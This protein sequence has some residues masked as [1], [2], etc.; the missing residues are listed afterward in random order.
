[1]FFLVAIG[2]EVFTLTFDF[3][4]SYFF[5]LKN[6]L[7]ELAVGLPP[8]DQDPGTDGLRGLMVSKLD[9][10]SILRANR[11]LLKLKDQG[12]DVEDINDV[13]R[14]QSL[15]LLEDLDSVT[16][17]SG[18]AKAKAGGTAKAKAV[19]KSVSKTGGTAKSK[20]SKPMKKETNE[21]KKRSKEERN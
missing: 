19:A 21:S 16:K 1:M 7:Q 5:P 17:P 4:I 2:V 20:G 11:N 10:K 12:Y 8:H 14:L 6:N 9:T 15:G 3:D 18:K 13:T